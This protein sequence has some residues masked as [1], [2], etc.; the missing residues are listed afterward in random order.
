MHKKLVT[1]EFLVG[2]LVVNVFILAG[3]LPLGIVHASTDVTGIITSDATWVKAN[4]PYT[5]TGPV[6]VNSG[7]TLTIEP[8]VTVNLNSYFIRVNGTLTARGSANDKI[9]FNGGSVVFTSVSNGWSEHTGSGSIFENTV[10]DSLAVEVSVKVTKSSF[11]ALSFDGGSSTVSYN[12]IG[13]LSVG[14]NASP[15]ITNND[16]TN[17][18]TL[19]GSPIVTSNNID[20]RPWVTG[21]SPVISN[22]Q[23][24]DGVHCDARSGQITISNNEIR[25]KNNY[26]LILV[27][28]THA[29]ISNNKLI[30]SSSKPMGITVSG[31]LSSASISQNQIYSCQTGISVDQSNVQISKNVIVDCDL[32]INIA[33]HAPIAGASA[34]WSTN[35]VVDVQTNT[36][37]RN[38]IGIQYL[39]YVLTSTISNNNIYDNSQYNFKLH[40]FSDN[41]TVSNNWWGTT[42]TTAIGQSIYDSSKDFTLGTVNFTPFLTAPNPEAPAIPASTPTP[43]PTLTPTP[44]PTSTQSPDTSP[45]QSP[46]A[47]PDQ[48]SAQTW[49]LEVAIVAIVVS[50]CINVLLVVVVAL[51]LRKRR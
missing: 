45:T 23:I 43:T 31:I 13:S 40:Q 9:Y 18:A 30:G 41:L 4:S 16:I 47:T 11:N 7:V 20:T 49:L 5:L 17:T 37:A 6:A 48:P 21:G 3:T 12:S 19:N 24:S 14:A 36:I 22:N 46:A 34:P 1:A 51:L 28:G 50:V 8:G 35:P 29:D 42:D 25:S 15:T 27:A 10:T 44:T 33:L 26:A 2:L 32:G 38:A 39:P